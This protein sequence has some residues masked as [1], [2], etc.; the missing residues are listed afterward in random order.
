[1][2]ERVLTSCRGDLVMIPVT[3]EHIRRD[4]LKDDCARRD[5]DILASLTTKIEVPVDL[6]WRSRSSPGASCCSWN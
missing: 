3:R 1:M 5:R 2:Q 6:S 4:E